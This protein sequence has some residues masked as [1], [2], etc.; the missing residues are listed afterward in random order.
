MARF[1]LQEVAGEEEGEAGEQGTVDE[2]HLLA[3]DERLATEP[4]YW[5]LGKDCTGME[6]MVELR[7]LSRFPTPSA[8]GIGDLDAL[9]VRWGFDLKPKARRRA[10][11]G[12][13]SRRQRRGRGR[14]R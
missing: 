1:S 11:I 2:Q 8:T 14:G 13:I 10:S 3:E 5:F 7:N 6:G 4:N 12:D 9:A